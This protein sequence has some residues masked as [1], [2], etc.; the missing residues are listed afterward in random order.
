MNLKI[1]DKLLN[2]EQPKI[3][4]ILNV[5]PDSFFDG[6]RFNTEIKVLNQVEKFINEGADIIDIGGYSS[7]PGAQNISIQTELKRVISNIKLIRKEFPEIFISIDTFRSEVARESYFSGADIINDISG[8]NLD[9]EMLK[10]V[11][12]LGAT[13]ILMHMRGNPQNMSLKTNYKNITQDILDYL[14]NGIELAKANGIND[15]IVDPG[16]GFAK[17]IKQ[18]FSLLNNLKDFKVLNYPILV[19]I[20]RK[21]MIYKTLNIDVQEALNGT[22]VLHT[23]ALLKGANI[24]RTHDVKEL[25]ECIKLIDELDC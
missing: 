5:T 15:I 16:F 25:M 19:G 3:M 7:R 6:G 4:A 22:T 9:T 2:L 1:R 21:S 14:S 18:N 23:V 8:G 11:G 10:T 20:S 13:Y 24:I 12:E 17:N